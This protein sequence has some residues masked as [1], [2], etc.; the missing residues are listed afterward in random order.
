M[1]VKDIAKKLNLSPATISLVLNDRPGI[2]EATREKVKAALKD[3]GCEDMLTARE[4]GRKNILF[5]VYRKNPAVGENTQRFS[6]VFSEIIE[7]VERQAKMRGFQLMILYMDQ[8][9]FE[10]ELGR[11]AGTRADGIILLAT[12]MWEEQIDRFEELGIPLVVLDNYIGKKPYDY[13]TI[14]NEMGVYEALSCLK[15]AGH[16][17]IGYFHIVENANN[18][19]ERYF[20]F[21]TAM[22][23]LELEI[24]ENFILEFNTA[25]GDTLQC[26][27][28]KRM[29]QMEEMPTAFF[30]DNDIVAICGIQ[31]LKRMGYRI[32]E[33][34][35]I[36]GFDDMPLSE[37]LDPPL[38]TI[39]TQKQT[40]GAVAVNLLIDKME[41]K[42]PGNLK[43][44]V[45]VSLIVR[46]S[47]G[48]LDRS[49]QNENKEK[50]SG[51]S[52]RRR[53]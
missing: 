50:V 38:T 21:G 14:N 12:E 5:V 27:M 48:R 36:I 31:S 16:E 28:Q 39:Q 26:E 44:E 29:E 1:K 9:S 32:P 51:D 7:G 41:E 46:Q 25:G 37:I 34:I 19:I 33:D 11:I 45:S 23:R 6:Q 15:E 17:K 40:M 47:V 22:R 24:N 30:A 8:N 2:S 3:M 53:L 35:S 43:V 49:D 18:F 52:L 20:A 4:S 13:V 10:T 42:F